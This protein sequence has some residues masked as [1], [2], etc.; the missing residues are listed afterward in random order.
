MI[1]FT[2]L[3]SGKAY[4]AQKPGDQKHRYI[5]QIDGTAPFLFIKRAT[6]IK[7]DN[8]GDAPTPPVLIGEYEPDKFQDSNYP[9]P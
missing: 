9:F 5:V 2:Q 7:V 6:F 1:S 8:E 3:E 4:W